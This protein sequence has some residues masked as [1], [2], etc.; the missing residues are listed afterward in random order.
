MNDSMI[1][2]PRCRN[3]HHQAQH[4]YTDSG[5]RAAICMHCE[6]QR[7]YIPCDAIVPP[8]TPKRKD[9]P[10]V[11]AVGSFPFF[12]SGAM[13]AARERLGQ[14]INRMGDSR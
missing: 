8:V 6:G 9:E 12:P 14:F 13:R 11:N 2:C 3:R 4:R 1:V 5:T 7:Q 10:T